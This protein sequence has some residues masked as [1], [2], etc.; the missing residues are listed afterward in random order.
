LLALA[1]GDPLGD[2]DGLALLLGDNDG[3]P[4]GLPDGDPL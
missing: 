3:L 2:P 1:E 4:E